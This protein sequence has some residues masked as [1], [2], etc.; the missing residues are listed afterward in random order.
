M[1]VANKLVGKGHND[2]DSL[3]STSSEDLN[4][5]GKDESGNSIENS[6]GKLPI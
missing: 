6:V 1:I 3:V 5:E 4:S 2:D